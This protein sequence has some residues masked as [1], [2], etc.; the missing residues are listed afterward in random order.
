MPEEMRKRDTV[1][2]KKQ[3]TTDN[4]NAYAEVM[5]QFEGITE[6]AN[7]KMRGMF[8]EFLKR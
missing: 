8:N 6:D 4:P 2:Y 5:M 1:Q 3:I 7:A